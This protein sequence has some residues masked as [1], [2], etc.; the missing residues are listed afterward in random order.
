[1]NLPNKLTT[2]RIILI[3]PFVILSI[4]FTYWLK[5]NAVIYWSIAIIFMISMFT[6]FLDGYLA[7]KWNQVTDYGKIMDP[8]A[9]K[10]ITTSTMIFLVIW[11]YMPFW[12]LLIFIVRD[13]IVDGL[14]IFYVQKNIKVEASIYGKMKTLM[15]TLAIIVVFIFMPFF[16]NFYWYILIPFYIATILCIIS[17]ILYIKNGSTL[18]L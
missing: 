13:I 4:L 7:R 1:M 18:L 12:I 16:A 15:Q 10:V 6:D 11:D 9:D 3:I 17:G 2:F 5:D 8:I 14:R